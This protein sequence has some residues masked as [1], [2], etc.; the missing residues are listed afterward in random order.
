[1]HHNV[2]SNI[3]T[4]VILAM[5]LAEELGGPELPEYITLMERIAAE[6]TQRAATARENMEQDKQVSIAEPKRTAA[7][8]LIG[9]LTSKLRDALRAKGCPDAVVFNGQRHTPDD[10]DLELIT[11]GWTPLITPANTRD[12]LEEEARKWIASTREA[13][14]AVD[15]EW[16]DLLIVD[17]L[18]GI[19]AVIEIE[20]SPYRTKQIEARF[21]A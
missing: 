6:A 5:Q 19:T 11:I 7:E 1:M 4:Q 13:I 9:Q 21:A 2:S 14:K 10:L 12:E 3:Y 15:N 17:Y 8:R 20:P 16:E 18:E